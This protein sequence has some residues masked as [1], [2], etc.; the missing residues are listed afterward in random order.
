MDDLEPG[1]LDIRNNILQA[2]YGLVHAYQ[3]EKL[4]RKTSSR[5]RDLDSKVLYNF[6]WVI[7]QFS[8]VQFVYS[9]TYSPFL[10]APGFLGKRR[11]RRTPEE[12]FKKSKRKKDFVHRKLRHDPQHVCAKFQSATPKDVRVSA[13]T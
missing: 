3:T 8:K 12:R 4:T 9:L 10:R 6:P 11:S 7:T 2:M 13:I 1:P 5:F